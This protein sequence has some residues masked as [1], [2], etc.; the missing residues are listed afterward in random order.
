MENI[1]LK[2]KIIP[3]SA[4]WQLYFVENP[5]LLDEIVAYDGFSDIFGQSGHAC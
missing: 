4:L 3:D 5:H 2:I 1:E